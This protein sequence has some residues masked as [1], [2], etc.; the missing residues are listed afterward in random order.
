MTF[1]FDEF[2]KKVNF[3]ELRTLADKSKSVGFSKVVPGEYMV[4][5]ENLFLTKS[6]SGNNMVKAKFK[7]IDGES[8]GR[9]IYMY[10]VVQNRTQIDI[11]NCFLN[12]L[13]TAQKVSFI[14]YTQYADVVKSVW[15]DANKMSY[16][17]LY[18]RTASG[19]DTFRI[20]DSF[21]AKK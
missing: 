3:D 9:D 13:S 4:K 11:C 10:Q 14:N 5:L 15:I 17:L 21:V 6:K 2:D 1:N 20:L 16:R 7:V 12:S 8:N 18:G 19:F